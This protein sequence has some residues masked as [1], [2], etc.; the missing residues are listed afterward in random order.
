MM[1]PRTMGVARGLVGGGLGIVPAA[2]AA[3]SMRVCQ[4]PHKELFQI[5]GNIRDLAGCSATT[6]SVDGNRIGTMMHGIEANMAVLAEKLALR[7]PDDLSNTT[8]RAFVS[9][10]AQD[11]FAQAS[12]LVRGPRGAHLVISDDILAINNMVTGLKRSL[13]QARNTPNM[14][15]ADAISINV[16]ARR[17]LTNIWQRAVLLEELFNPS[18]QA[19]ERIEIEE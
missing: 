18:N 7:E 8:I 2:S 11:F 6:F 5:F 17:D 15:P 1:I 10:L 14:D 4:V 13:D 19:C 3:R 16:N 9:S 12:S